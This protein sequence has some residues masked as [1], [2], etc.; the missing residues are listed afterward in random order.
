VSKGR[1]VGPGVNIATSANLKN[2]RENSPEL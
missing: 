1:S 2:I